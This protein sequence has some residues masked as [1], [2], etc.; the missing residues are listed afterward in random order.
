M[1]HNAYRILAM[2]DLEW[3]EKQER[4]SV[5]R[6]RISED[7]SATLSGPRFGSEI[8]ATGQTLASAIANLRAKVEKAE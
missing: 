6:W 7:W 8:Q 5:A 3:L 4:V 1:T 2:A